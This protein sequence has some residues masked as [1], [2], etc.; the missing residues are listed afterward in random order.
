M[1]AVGTHARQ[2]PTRLPAQHV[3]GGQQA[4][5]TQLRHELALRKQT[6]QDLDGTHGE[7]SEAAAG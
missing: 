5:R 2:T 6:T 7:L 3:A 1:R 4:A